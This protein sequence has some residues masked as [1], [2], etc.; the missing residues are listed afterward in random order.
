MK[1]VGVQRVIEY[2]GEKNKQKRS[3]SE[4][5]KPQ[6]SKNNIKFQTN[7]EPE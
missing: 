7:V 1:A 6:N 2:W 5:F 3:Y 4:P